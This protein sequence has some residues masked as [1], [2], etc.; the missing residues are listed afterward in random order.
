MN[1][2]FA[3]LAATLSGLAVALGALGAHAVKGWLSTRA[4]ADVRLAWWE[5]ATRFHFFHALGLF[6]VAVLL[7][8]AQSR[9]AAAAGWL[10]LLGVVL[11]SGSLYA[12]TLTGNRALAVF[13]P[14]GGVSFLAGWVCFLVAARRLPT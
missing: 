12:M 3:T 6:A 11:F 2:R 7:K 10:L 14:F 13:T 4:E 1:R 9:I 5:T 8:H